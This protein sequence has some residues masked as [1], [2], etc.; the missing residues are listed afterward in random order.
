MQIGHVQLITWGISGKKACLD[1]LHEIQGNLPKTKFPVALKES[2][3]SGMKREAENV[4]RQLSKGAREAQTQF[5]EYERWARD[6]PDPNFDEKKRSNQALIKD[7]KHRD[8][9]FDQEC[10]KIYRYAK[11]HDPNKRWDY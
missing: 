5:R 10:E 7:L 3:L 6:N 9:A 1:A 8:G 2:D 4:S 11:A